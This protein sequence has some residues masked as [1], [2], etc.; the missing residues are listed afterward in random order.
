MWRRGSRIASSEPTLH[1]AKRGESLPVAGS[2]RLPG[3]TKGLLQCRVDARKRAGSEE[4][5]DERCD[6]VDLSFAHVDEDRPRAH[7]GDRPP[8]A[9]EDPA[10]DV[11]GMNGLRGDCQRPIE[12]G[13][14][15]TLEQPEP[16]SR[17]RDRG[18]DDSEELEALETEHG[19]DVVV[20][21]RAAPREDPTEEGSECQVIGPR[22]GA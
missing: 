19:L 1:R 4:S 9:E 20:I 8:D 10:D 14:L 13:A 16:G 2:E 5:T 17:D 15:A 6:G 11:A 7:P 3:K 22:H 18:A 21:G 12:E